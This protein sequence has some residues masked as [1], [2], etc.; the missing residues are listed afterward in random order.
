MN[1][2]PQLQ[3]DLS[4]ADEWG[5]YKN[6]VPNVSS[7]PQGENEFSRKRQIRMERLFQFLMK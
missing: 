5:F 4:P 2:I 7:F 6:T 3:M 1:Q